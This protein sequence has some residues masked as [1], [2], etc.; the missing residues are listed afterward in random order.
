MVDGAP[1]DRGVRDHVLDLVFLIGVALKGLDGL[2]ELL[3]G[4]PL[5]FLSHSQVTSLARHL[6][7]EELTE[8]PHDLV[9]NLLLHG[10]AHAGQ[11]ALLFV[12]LYLL[13]HGVV[14]LAIVLALIWGKERVYPWAIGALALFAAFQTVEFVL[15]PSVSV[16]LLTALDVLIIGLTWREWRRHHSLR[17]TLATTVDWMCSGRRARRGRADRR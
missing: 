6:T 11:G 8:D 7:A 15:H 9:A 1:R 10:A 12:G 14:K 2:G 17:E 13:V 3:L 5:L 4:F 16:A